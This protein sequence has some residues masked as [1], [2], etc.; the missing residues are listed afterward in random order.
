MATVSAY[1]DSK[2]SVTFRWQIRNWNDNCSTF[3]GL[4]VNSIHS[5]LFTNKNK[6]QSLAF[7]I[8]CIFSPWAKN[9]L[10]F[11]FGSLALWFLL[12]FLSPSKFHPIQ[13]SISASNLKNSAPS[14]Y[15]RILTFQLCRREDIQMCLW[16]TAARKRLGEI[17]SISTILRVPPHSRDKSVLPFC[18]T[19]LRQTAPSSL[20]LF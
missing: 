12:P 4:L 2:L 14:R 16:M 10:K 15:S 19:P 13:P 5:L 3:G 18:P 9:P 8:S 6:S 17:L 1:G 20:A 7:G 11:F